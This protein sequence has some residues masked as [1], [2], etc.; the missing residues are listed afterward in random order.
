MKHLI[1]FAFFV[2]T[3]SHASECF[4]APSTVERAQ[5]HAKEIEVLDK[6]LNAEYKDAIAELK[7]ENSRVSEDEFRSAQR[8]WVTFIEADCKVKGKLYG[9]TSI[10]QT[11]EYQMCRKEYYEKR[12]YLFKI[13][14]YKAAP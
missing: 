1:F 13:A 5:C 6:E 4:D 7:K 10:W 11:I 14:S 12:I 3:L 2:S 8:L 9:G